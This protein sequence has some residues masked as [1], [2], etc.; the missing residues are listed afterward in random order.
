MVGCV[1]KE[2]LI[3]KNINLIFQMFYDGFNV[4]I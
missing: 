2:Y 3:L 4:L 1:L